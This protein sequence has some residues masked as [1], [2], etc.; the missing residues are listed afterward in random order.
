MATHSSRKLKN[1]TLD[2]LYEP[3]GWS[4]DDSRLMVYKREISDQRSDLIVID[5]N[6][7]QETYTPYL[8]AGY[9]GISMDNRILY[10]IKPNLDGSA[11]SL[12]AYDLQKNESIEL[13]PRMKYIVTASYNPIHNVFLI[14]KRDEYFLWKNTPGAEMQLFKKKIELAVWSHDWNKLAYLDTK[15]GEMYVHEY[16]ERTDIKVT[17]FAEQK[18]KK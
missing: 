17:D 10:L 2:Q 12:M 1:L 3:I 5:L 8:D 4:P 11:G 18:T 14:Q 9:A 6:S 13:L 7:G 15:D 16:Q